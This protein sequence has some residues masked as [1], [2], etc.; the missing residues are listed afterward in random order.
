MATYKKLQVKYGDTKLFS[1][2]IWRIWA[3]SLFSKTG[4]SLAKIC[5]KKIQDPPHLWT[6]KKL[7]EFDSPHTLFYFW[8]LNELIMHEVYQEDQIPDWEFQWHWGTP[9]NS[10]VEQYIICTLKNKSH[11]QSTLIY[12]FKNKRSCGLQFVPTQVPLLGWVKGQVTLKGLSPGLQNLMFT[13][14]FGGDYWK[15]HGPG[16]KGLCLKW[17]PSLDYR[18]NHIFFLKKIGNVTALTFHS[19]FYL[20]QLLSFF[21]LF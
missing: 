2:K 1:F 5:H 8:A 17:K 14:L 9:L 18:S 10:C 3:L 20:I 21:F 7:L 11:V 4:R 15:I 13:L 16:L 6:I 19:F 12:A